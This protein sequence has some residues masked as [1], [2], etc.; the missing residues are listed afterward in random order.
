[1]YYHIHVNIRTNMCYLGWMDITGQ[2]NS[3]ELT[4]AKVDGGRDRVPVCLTFVISVSEN[5]SWAVVRNGKT[6]PSNSKLLSTMPHLIASVQDVIDFLSSLVPTTRNSSPWFSS[7]C[8]E[9]N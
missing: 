5:F 4:L 9:G 8:A 3:R 7:R 2:V 6:F 1:M